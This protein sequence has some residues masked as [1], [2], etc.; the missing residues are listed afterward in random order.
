MFATN[1]EKSTVKVL[2]V[3]VLYFP[4]FGITHYLLLD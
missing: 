3:T 1:M 4:F 2:S